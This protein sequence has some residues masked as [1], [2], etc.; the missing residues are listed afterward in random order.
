[1]VLYILRA[2]FEINL[3][4]LIINFNVHLIHF[5]KV[6]H[7]LFSDDL[8]PWI[9][10]IFIFILTQQIIFLKNIFLR[11]IFFFIKNKFITICTFN[12]VQFLLLLISAGDRPLNFVLTDRSFKL[13]I[14]R[15]F[16][17][18]GS[19]GFRW[20]HGRWEHLIRSKICWRNKLLS[21]C[22]NLKW[23]KLGSR[24]SSRH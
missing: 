8:V 1:M 21:W 14:I 20:F 23:F 3:F 22:I 15:Y 12:A 10:Y 4:I 24:L 18:D 16:S 11:F 13:L 6:L 9:I 7:Q 17:C 2:I 19:W 5:F